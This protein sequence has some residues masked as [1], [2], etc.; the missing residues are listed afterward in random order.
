MAILCS[1]GGVWF[2][3]NRW[4][5]FLLWL[6]SGVY[7]ERR[8]S[9]QFRRFLL[10]VQPPV[11]SISLTHKAVFSVFFLALSLRIGKCGRG[12]DAYFSNLHRVC[13]FFL[14]ITIWA[15]DGA[16]LSLVVN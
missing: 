13:V 11:F 5:Y 4:L 6:N 12:L 3:E 8:K 16:N 9:Y 2:V 7:A 1:V 10:D 15:L 14:T